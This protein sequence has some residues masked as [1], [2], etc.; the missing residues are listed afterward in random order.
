MF[1]YQSYYKCL[2]VKCYSCKNIEQQIQNW[3]LF[4]EFYYVDLF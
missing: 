1:H 3:S 2:G 4:Q